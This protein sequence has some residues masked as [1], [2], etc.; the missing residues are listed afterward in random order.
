MI[1]LRVAGGDAEMVIRALDLR[2]HPEG[3]HYRET[4]RDS[5]LDGGRGAGEAEAQLALSVLPKLPPL[6]PLATPV[7]DQAKRTALQ[8]MRMTVVQALYPCSVG[9]AGLA[10]VAAGPTGG[11]HL[12][13][14]EP[15]EPHSQSEGQRDRPREGKDDDV[16]ADQQSEQAVEDS[17]RDT[18]GR[19]T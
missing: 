5:P 12:D 9:G 4:W 10:L 8:A 13:D 7:R 11:D 16:E 18:A 3:G 6:P 14:P 15:E 17:Q 19:A 2:P 1:D